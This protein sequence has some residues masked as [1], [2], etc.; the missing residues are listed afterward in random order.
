M[1]ASVQPSRQD[2]SSSSAR[3]RS[4]LGRRRGATLGEDST[5]GRPKGAV[6][7][8]ALPGGA[9]AGRRVPERME[10]FAC[11]AHVRPRIADY[12]RKPSYVII[13]TT[14]LTRFNPGPAWL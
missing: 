10:L 3:R 7:G 8:D 13:S 5:A 4:G 14:A 11:L 12:R 6:G 9:V 2:A 1:I